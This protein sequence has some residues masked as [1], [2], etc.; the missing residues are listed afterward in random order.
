MTGFKN[1]ILRGNLV[2]LAVALVIALSFKT[3]IDAT[4]AV[5]TGLVGK[6]GGNPDFS[7]YKPGG[8]LIGIWITA[9]VSF[10]ITAA[11]VYYLIVVPYTE[12]KE[13]Y[14]PSPEPGT[15][16]DIK[17]LQEIRDLLVQQNG[18]GAATITPPLPE[19]AGRRARPVTR[20][21]S[22]ISQPWCGGTCARSHRSPASSSVASVA[23]SGP[24]SSDV[25]SGS[26]S[27][28]TSASRR[29]RSQ[30][31]SS[32]SGWAGLSSCGGRSAIRRRGRWRDC[33]EPS[34]ARP[35]RSSASC[36]A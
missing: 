23:D 1:F 18:G 16:E 31:G 24:R 30:S 21:G 27:P 25:V 20:S 2:E 32:G 13:R 14:F 5:I 28:N 15:P 6:I 17:L 4:V 33:P 26:T 11:I 22:F 12:A 36:C 10:L 35:R 29:R 8:L 9:V 3:V 19:V 34:A 7:D